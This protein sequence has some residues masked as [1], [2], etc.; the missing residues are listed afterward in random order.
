MVFSVSGSRDMSSFSP[1]KKFPNGLPTCTA[2][3]WL[4]FKGP[5]AILNITCS[6]FV[7]KGTSYRPGRLT[8]PITERIFVPLAFS[9]PMPAYDSP[10][11]SIMW[12]M[13]AKVST[14]FTMVG[15]SHKPFSMGKGGLSRGSPTSPSRESIRA[16]SSPHT[17]DPPPRMI[18]KVKLKLDPKMFLPK[19]P[20]R[21]AV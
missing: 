8:L 3:I 1:G 6:K 5:P 20:Y 21:L 11:C 14:L 10:P 2:F 17:Y 19:K 13:F 15:R 9:V 16:V 4:P 18:F 12:G 7:P